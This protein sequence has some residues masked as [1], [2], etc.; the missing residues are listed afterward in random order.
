M[1]EVQYFEDFIALLEGI[2]QAHI[3][4]LRKEIERFIC[5][6][7]MSEST[8]SAFTKKMLLLAERYSLDVLKMVASGV[9]VDQ[10][11]AHSNPPGEL[12]NISHEL[13]RMASEINDSLPTDP[14][15]PTEEILVGSVVE[16]LQSLTRRVRRVSLSH[17]PSSTTTSPSSTPPGGATPTDESALSPA[18]IVPTARPF[19]PAVTPSRFKRIELA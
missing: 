18:P 13:K 3:P 7:V 17:S 16:D 12:V 15:T 11:I 1:K 19:E 2:G 10:I 4:P 14:T 9:L 6:E 5:R 8:D